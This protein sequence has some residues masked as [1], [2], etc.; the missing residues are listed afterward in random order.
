MPK[1]FVSGVVVSTS[2]VTVSGFPLAFRHKNLPTVKPKLPL[3]G[4]LV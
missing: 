3:S 1:N 2:I 4:S